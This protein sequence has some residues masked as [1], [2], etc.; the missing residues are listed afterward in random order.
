MRSVQPKGGNFSGGASGAFMFFS[1]DKRY[2][3]K[4][5]TKVCPRNRPGVPTLF[6]PQL[7][8]HRLS[9]GS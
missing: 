5:L 1:G 6:S 2:I 9:L 7:C 8:T 4:T 3:V